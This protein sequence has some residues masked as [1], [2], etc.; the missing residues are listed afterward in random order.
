MLIYI[1]ALDY[2]GAPLIWEY[3]E[4]RD[5]ATC[6][7][8]VLRK[9]S[10]SSATSTIQSLRNFLV[11]DNLQKRKI[12]GLEINSEKASITIS[13][14]KSY[15]NNDIHVMEPSSSMLVP[16]LDI[17]S[18][19]STPAP[20]SMPVPRR[21]PA[22]AAESQA[23]ASPHDAPRVKTPRSRTNVKTFFDS[24]T[25]GI[26]PTPPTRSLPS[27]GSSTQATIKTSKTISSSDAPVMGLQLEAI[28]T[29]SID[30]TILGDTERYLPD[31][32]SGH[33]Y[34]LT[35]FM[36]DLET[37][38][39][40]FDSPTTFSRKVNYLEVGE[41]IPIKELQMHLLR[42]FFNEILAPL[43]GDRPL[44]P[45]LG[46]FFVQAIREVMRNEPEFYAGFKSHNLGPTFYEEKSEEELAGEFGGN[47]HR[48][49]DA[50]HQVLFARARGLLRNFRFFITSDIKSHQ[51]TEDRT[52]QAELDVLKSALKSHR[53]SLAEA[54]LLL[55][56]LTELTAK[57]GRIATKY[58]NITQILKTQ[59]EAKT[60]LSLAFLMFKYEKFDNI[61]TDLLEEAKTSPELQKLRENLGNLRVDGKSCFHF[62]FNFLKQKYTHTK[63]EHLQK[64]TEKVIEETVELLKTVFMADSSVPVIRYPADADFYLPEEMVGQL[65]AN[66]P[67]LG[68][69]HYEKKKH[70]EELITLCSQWIYS[71]IASKL[72]QKPSEA[73]PEECPTSTPRRRSSTESS[74]KI[75]FKEDV[76]AVS[77]SE[78]KPVSS[79]KK[80]GWFAKSKS[81]RD[82]SEKNASTPTSDHPPTKSQ[83]NPHFS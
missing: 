29:K 43:Y 78:D 22:D 9:S 19:A 15:F 46:D 65:R 40:V 56:Q 52:V 2:H 16:P 49:D 26:S 68:Q 8:Q 59:M 31:S 7:F 70:R 57:S 67:D 28:L 32:K 1:S 79:P 18:I 11:I 47:P 23:P 55:E 42:V 12:K 3:D 62:I 25:S 35:K 75:K 44:D 24:S 37:R 54:C 64:I 58:M 48:K 60:D 72:L 39:T 10:E 63:E 73:R 30:S 77:S 14:V 36:S 17:R 80:S 38:Q 82:L 33:S 50:I 74:S 45:K 21:S 66:P 34:F 13:H 51:L 6:L 20:S 69:K 4:S 76:H 27:P 71:A 5:E 41:L 53:S 61:E 83:V 81:L